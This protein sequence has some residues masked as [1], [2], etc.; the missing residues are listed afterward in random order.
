MIFFTSRNFASVL[1]L[2]SELFLVVVVFFFFCEL[3]VFFGLFF[4][5]CGRHMNAEAFFDSETRC[6]TRGWPIC[7]FRFTPFAPFFFSHNWE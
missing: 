1:F 4:L 3:A 6:E 7:G 5:S 2:A